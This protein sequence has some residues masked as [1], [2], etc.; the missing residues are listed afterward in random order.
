MAESEE[1]K[2]YSKSVKSRRL[3]LETVG[4][5]PIL[6]RRRLVKKDSKYIY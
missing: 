4:V 1:H 2:L 6:R 5:T 3:K